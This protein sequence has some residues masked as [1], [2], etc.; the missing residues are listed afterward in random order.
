MQKNEVSEVDGGQALEAFAKELVGTDPVANL[1]LTTFNHHVGGVL[2]TNI[3]TL[4]DLLLAVRL[5]RSFGE[6][7]R[8]FCAGRLV[9]KFELDPLL[10]DSH[11]D[12]DE[13]AAGYTFTKKLT[14]DALSAQPPFN[15]NGA[16]T[17]NNNH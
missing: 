1:N 4:E 8:R 3:N 9:A 10:V 5:M 11:K 2:M 13:F 6:K 12:S 14:R 17:C 16:T 7:L 15:R